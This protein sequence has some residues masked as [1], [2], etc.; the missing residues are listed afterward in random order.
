MKLKI[1]ILIFILTQSSTLFPQSRFNSLVLIEKIT[2]T[3]D[4]NGIKIQFQLKKSLEGNP[5]VEI[6]SE[7]I[8][9]IFDN[10]YVITPKSEIQLDYQIFSKIRIIQFN[11]KTVKALIYCN[12]IIPKGI[13][14]EISF[15]NA[16]QCIISI[17]YPA[18]PVNAVD[19][20]TTKPTSTSAEKIS[21]E[22]SVSSDEPEDKDLTTEQEVSSPTPIESPLVQAQ[23]EDKKSSKG[24]YLNLEDEG[25]KGQPPD[26]QNTSYDDSLIKSLFKSFASLLLILGLIILTVY[27]LKR[28]FLQKG[29]LG[30]QGKTMKLLSSIY[31]GEKKRICLVEVL[32]KILVLG[33]TPNSIN[34]LTE[35]EGEK[36][37]DI[38]S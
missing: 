1:L 30:G 7:R 18:N 16:L 13:K 26:S 10:T 31:I 29:E 27:L 37:M 35:V 8:D 9:F 23:S 12:G 4:E 11:S 25:N 38:V 33:I 17:P 24:T 28:F 20:N 14:P 15:V 21:K 2:K 6:K 32:G 5:K 3:E 34:L 22:N 36:V 19:T